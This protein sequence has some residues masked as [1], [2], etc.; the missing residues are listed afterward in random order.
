MTVAWS[1]RIVL[2]SLISLIHNYDYNQEKNN[3]SKV[4]F[5]F[6]FGIC[7][8]HCLTTIEYRTNEEARFKN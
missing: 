6:K 2:T 4:F 1:V 7:L 3:G 8:I 5:S